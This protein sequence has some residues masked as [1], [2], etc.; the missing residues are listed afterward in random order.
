M[1]ILIYKK[2]NLLTTT[3]G[4]EKITIQMANHFA[5][6]GHQVT[7]LTRDEKDG[8]SFF[9]PSP[10]V[11]VINLYP[12][13][14]GTFS[15]FRRFINKLLYTTQSQQLLDKFPFFD[16]EKLVSDVTYAK[17]QEI[18]PDIII[19]AGAADLVDLT[20][21]K[22]YQTPIIVMLHSRPSV[23]FDIKN[24]I[25]SSLMLNEINKAN[26]VQV[27]L[28]S[29]VEDA[30]K[31]YQGKI[32]VIGNNIPA[33]ENQTQYAKGKKDYS[34]IYMARFDN[35]KQQDFLIKSF[36]SLINDYPEWKVNLWG[37][38]KKSKI[39][40]IKKL[41]HQYRLDKNVFLKGTTDTPYKELAQADICAFPSKFEGFG[42]ALGEAMASGL[43]CVGLKSASAVNELIIDGYN[44]YLCSDNTKDFANKL[45]KLMASP[46]LRKEL[47]QNAK[48]EISKYAPEIVWKQWDDLIAELTDK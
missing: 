31:Y 16:R 3:G 12:Q 28:P 42:I 47:G 44:G 25:K 22:E 46:E 30:K 17:I 14:K 34:I 20:Y 37:T 43:P 29:F 5:D 7:L 18:K 6:E 38:G 21:K 35:F 19:T 33:P 24:K 36:S 8:K 39:N 2:N 40:S 4:A 11:K 23:Y 13:L 27:L 1:K 9:K 32:K 45:A 48:K 15:P 10:K 26:A 41:I